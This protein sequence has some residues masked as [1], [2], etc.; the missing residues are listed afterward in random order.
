MAAEQAVSKL[1]PNLTPRQLS[2]PDR[3]LPPTLPLIISTQDSWNPQSCKLETTKTDTQ[4]HHLQLVEGTLEL[5]RSIDKPLAILSICGPYRSGKSYFMSRLLGSPG[6]FQLGHSM[7]ACTRG[8]WMAT[9]ILECEEFA[10]IFLDTEGIDAVGASETMAMS[11][12]TLTTLLSS[13]LIYNSKK[14]PQ[15]VDLDKMRCFS[16]L[17]TSL[18]AQ[19]GDC[20]T[21]E[22]MKKFFPRFLW[23]LRDVHLAIT[24]KEGKKITPTE[25]LHTRILT[26]EC[27]E[28]TELGSSLCN[29][30]PSLECCTLPVPSIKKEVI[31][32]IVE[33]EDKLKPAFNTAVNELIQQIL[34]QVA[35]KMAIDG[36]S[37]VN[38]STF[39]ALACGYVEA[40]N[41]PGALPNLEQGWQAVIRLQIK[42]YTDKLVKEYEREME[43]LL[44]G[45]LPLEERNLMRIHEQKLIKK[46][47]KLQQEVCRISPLN[48]ST[49]DLDPFFS[50]LEQEIIKWSRPDDETEREV[51]GGVLFQFTTQNYS[52]SKQHCEELFGKLVEQFKLKDKV[53][54][55]VQSSKTLEIQE[56]IQ[57][58]THHYNEVA[59]GPAASEVMEKGL[60]EL[61]QLEKTLKM[62]PGCPQDVEV[63][64]RG[65]NRIKLSWNPPAHNPEAA[66][67][68]VVSMRVEGGA[69]EEAKRTKQ[70]KALV[71]GLKSKKKYEFKVTATNSVMRSLENVKETKTELSKADIAVLLS[72]VGAAMPLMSVGLKVH[73]ILEKKILGS[74]LGTAAKVGI[75]AAT[76]PLSLLLTPAVPPVVA[77]HLAAEVSVDRNRGDLTPVSDDEDM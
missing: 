54:E 59:V 44:K 49:E 57:A 27:G 30:F 63:I 8:I 4:H 26:S 34:Q 33:Q 31:R 50:Q 52:E 9:T 28:P 73:A 51:V 45:I 21:T 64:G 53:T 66:E 24:D 14:V 11:L 74:E 47:H 13:Y 70:T 5:L 35:P 43:E 37:L 69:W 15:K 12:L 2:L 25:F 19:R 18:L 60:M 68:Y 6:A 10:T 32:N 39:A 17:S 75:Y 56:E 42:E 20:M 67:L 41:T 40:I 29:L 38:G 22:A 55:A 76:A 16:Q 23:L 72:V 77:I 65:P 58:I 1:A 48:S 46:R 7:R 62:I 36:V 3:T 71:T 61:N